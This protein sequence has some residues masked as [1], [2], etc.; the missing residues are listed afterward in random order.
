[1]IGS[2]DS[3]NEIVGRKLSP[4]K[5]KETSHGGGARLLPRHRATQYNSQRPRRPRCHR[6]R[7]HR[8]RTRG[9]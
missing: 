3:S 6:R 5:D 9:F 4:R 1:M 7:H 8:R 2:R